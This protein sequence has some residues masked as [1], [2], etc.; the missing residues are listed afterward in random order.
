MV[1]TEMS[2]VPLTVALGNYDRHWP[3]FSGEVQAEGIDLKAFPM[4][5]EEIFWRQAQFTDFDACEFAGASYIILR[6]RD[7]NPFT[8]IPVFPS[9]SFRHNAVYVN[10]NAGIAKP[11][12]L[13]GKRM[14]VPE[15]EMT[16]MLWIRDFLQKDYGV[17]PAD[18]EWFTGG[19]R[20]RG[21]KPRVTYDLPGGVVVHPPEPD[22]TLDDM[23]DRGEIDALMAA[24]IPEPMVSG[25]P[26]IR[27]LFPN[28]REVESDYFRRTG[29]FPIMHAVVIRNDIIQKYPWIPMNLYWAFVRARDLAVDRLRDTIASAATMPSTLAAV[30]EDLALMGHDFWPYGAESNR[31]HYGYLVSLTFEQGLAVR[32]VPYEELYAPSCYDEFKI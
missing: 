16:A 19:Q 12:D 13:K 26:N 1:S 15:Y 20:D 29:L 6:A 2:K 24:R 28:F 4:T 23:L 14:G 25:S 10:A 11:Q 21:R 8:A 32:E 9:R 18:M 5:I 17:A 7:A 30:E 22:K 31:K 3:L 27:R